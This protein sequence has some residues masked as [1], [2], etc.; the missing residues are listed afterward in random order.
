MY[1]IIHDGEIVATTELERGDP[2]AHAVSGVVNNMGGPKALANWI[3]SIGG[4]EDD[5]VV[6]VELNDEFFLLD[7]NGR[8]L[9]FQEGNLIAVPAEDES[10]L[11]ITGVSEEDY[12]T[13]FAGH[14]SAMENEPK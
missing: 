7:E 5:G 11:D 4:Q 3:K 2:S 14:I 10:Y 9:R 8:A 6:F 13:Y 12:N 1:T